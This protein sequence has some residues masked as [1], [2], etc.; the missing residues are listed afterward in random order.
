MSEFNDQIKLLIS[1]I[2]E[3]EK[4]KLLARF[5]RKDMA[6]AKRLFFE[7]MNTETVDEK[8]AHLA[9]KIDLNL[10]RINQNLRS[11]DPLLIQL[12]EISGNINDHVYETKD[13]FGEI[14]LNL[15]MLNQTFN[16]SLSLLQKSSS[17]R[18]YAFNLY[19]VARIFRTLIQITKLHE[20]FRIEFKSDLMLLR[21]NMSQVPALMDTAIRHGLDLNWIDVYEIPSNIESIHRDIRKSGF[22]R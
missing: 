15:H 5:L 6:L 4:D 19:V 14:S 22:L 7:Y 16:T 2:S 3:K 13:K 18:M 12:R 20:D 17:F 8:R 9:Q 21:N 10:E 1:H 11:V